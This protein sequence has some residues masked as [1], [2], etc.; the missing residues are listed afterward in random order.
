ME[1]FIRLKREFFARDTQIVAKDLLGKYLVRKTEK[2]TKV[3]KI[4]EDEAYLE[5]KPDWFSEDRISISLVEGET[6]DKDEMTIVAVL[7]EAANLEKGD[8]IEL[9]TTFLP[10]PGIDTMKGKGYSAWT[11]KSEGDSIRTYF[12][13]ELNT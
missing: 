12:I 5:S 3:G 13:K 7:R 11:M 9:I 8:I 2:G 10:A 4:I 6:A 1:P